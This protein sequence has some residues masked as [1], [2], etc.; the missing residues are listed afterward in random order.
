[1]FAKI[2][3]LIFSGNDQVDGHVGG[4]DGQNDPAQPVK[5]GGVSAVSEGQVDQGVIQGP[6]HRPTK[7]RNAHAKKAMP[8][9]HSFGGIISG[10]PQP[11][12]M[13]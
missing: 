13:S 6:A 2:K 9:G 11:P 4:A 5:D 7:A 1:M 8:N 12:A 10:V 3:T